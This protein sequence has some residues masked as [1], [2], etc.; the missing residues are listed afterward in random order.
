MLLLPCPFAFATCAAQSEWAACC[1][2]KMCRPKCWCR[3]AQ[4]SADLELS[5][6]SANCS[7]D[8]VDRQR[9]RQRA[10]HPNARHPFSE[11][12]AQAFRSIL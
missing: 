9:F 10:A 4:V 7:G 1:L 3:L 2:E 6:R 8:V 5:V 11:V 12:N